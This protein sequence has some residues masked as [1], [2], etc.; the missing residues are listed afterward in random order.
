MPMGEQV[1][2]I[3]GI[4]IKALRIENTNR[5][6]PQPN[7]IDGKMRKSIIFFTIIFSFSSYA[8]VI[9][10]PERAE[11]LR[12]DGNVS[13]IYDIDNNGNVNNIRV[14]NAEPKYVFERSVVKQISRWKFPRNDEKKNIELNVIFDAN[15]KFSSK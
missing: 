9:K 2:A 15:Q 8:N 5:Y 10:Y 1:S 14:L 11:S 4:Y 12:I 6:H 7:L 13:I 3:L